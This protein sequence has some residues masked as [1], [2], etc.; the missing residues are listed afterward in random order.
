M[1][2]SLALCGFLFVWG[3][4][5]LWAGVIHV[6][7]DQGTIQGGIDAAGAGDEVVAAVGTYSEIIDFKGKAITVRSSDCR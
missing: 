2:R 1:S 4:G 7:G 5:S 3:S 6:P